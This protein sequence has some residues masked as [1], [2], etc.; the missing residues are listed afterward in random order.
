MSRFGIDNNRDLDVKDAVETY[1][2]NVLVDNDDDC[3]YMIVDYRENVEFLASKLNALAESEAKLVGL[4]EFMLKR[5]EVCKEEYDRLC[6]FGA[7]TSVV[8]YEIELLGELVG[9]LK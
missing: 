3:F 4:K 6:Y 9:M 8:L 7:S 2:M 5:L 1:E